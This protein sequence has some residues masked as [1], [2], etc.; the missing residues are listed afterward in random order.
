MCACTL[1]P[2]REWG[3]ARARREPVKNGFAR[4]IFKITEGSQRRHLW[5]HCEG[6]H[7]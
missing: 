6:R 3:V 7:F 2:R 5:R 4:R 1:G